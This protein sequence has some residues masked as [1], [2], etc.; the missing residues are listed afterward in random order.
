MFD[1][2]KNQD[3]LLGK[4]NRIVEGTTINGDITTFADFRLD[5]KLTGNFTSEGKIVIGPTGEV[6]GDI[7]CKNI[8]IEGVFSGKLQAEGMLNVKSKAHITGEVIVGKLAVEPGAR[9][10]ASCEMRTQNK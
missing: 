4:T 6:I 3:H 9:F 2:V 8:D 5:G 7:I 1:K 10:E